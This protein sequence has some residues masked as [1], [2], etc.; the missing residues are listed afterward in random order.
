MTNEAQMMKEIFE[1]DKKTSIGL[2]VPTGIYKDET[3][4][5]DWRGSFKAVINDRL[6]EMVVT[7]S[8]L[9]INDPDPT[10]P[11]LNMMGGAWVETEMGKLYH[12]GYKS[13]QINGG[14]QIFRAGSGKPFAGFEKKPHSHMLI[15]TD[16][17]NE[18]TYV[19]VQISFSNE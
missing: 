3:D 14:F 11:V 10:A 9:F 8:T 1:N 18:K 13:S 5:I 19:P 6:F 12:A 17:N 4:F 16:G 7:P 2:G 15:Y